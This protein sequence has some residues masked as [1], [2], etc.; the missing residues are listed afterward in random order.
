MH[1]QKKEKGRSK[2]VSVFVFIIV[3]L[4]A[5]ISLYPLIWVV[6][7]SFKTEP[8]FLSSIWSLPSSLHLDNYITAFT[9]GNLAVYLKNT[10]INT[11][12]TLVVEIVFITLAAFA[13]SKLKMKFKNVIFYMILINMLIPTP[14][15]LLPMYLQVINLNIQ[16]T[17]AAIVFPYFQGFAPLGL[18][19]LKNYM[20]GIPNEIIEAAKIDG[21]STPRILLSIMVPLVKPMMVT[22]AILGGMSAW[23]EYMWALV[24]ISDT[25]KYTLSVGIAILKDKI[26]TLGYTPVLAALTVGAMV[27]VIIYLAAQK[28]FVRSITEGAVKG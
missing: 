6:L 11:G 26:S 5:L 7:Q 3:L 25:S 22:L 8:E 2:N 16:N 27:F 12:A 18:I 28:T 14:I 19:L 17:L 21:C 1:R 4:Y 13:F 24:S 23:N 20:D 9:K 10:V 15:I